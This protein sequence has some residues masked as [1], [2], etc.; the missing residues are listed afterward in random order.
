M[1][2]KGVANDNDKAF[3]SKISPQQQLQM[4]HNFKDDGVFF[5]L[6]DDFEKYFV[7]LDICRVDDNAHY[8]YLSNNF[9]RGKPKL[10]QITT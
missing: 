5:M 2:W 4:G 10:F 6:W 1:E 9:Q 8:F 3:W 7:V